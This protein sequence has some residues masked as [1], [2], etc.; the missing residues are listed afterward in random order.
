MYQFIKNYMMRRAVEHPQFPKYIWKPN[1]VDVGCGSGVGSNILSQE[2][3]FVWGID[4]N[5]FSIEFAKEAFT[6]EKNKV[7]YTP[8]ISFDIV[9]IMSD[10][11]EFMKFDYV[12]AIEVIEHIYDTHQF[13]RQLIGKFTKRDKRGNAHIE[14]PTEFFISTPNRAHPKIRKDKPQNMYHVREWTGVEFDSFMR[15]YF[16]RVEFLNQKGE[17]V[18]ATSAVDQVLLVKCWHPKI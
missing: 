18:L 8:Q 6:R 15:Q 10:N 2:A 5:E 9:D 4:K 17:P 3:N 11:R 14:P 1:V 12:V 16:E 13:L 7:Y